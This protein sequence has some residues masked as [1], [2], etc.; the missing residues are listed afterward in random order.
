MPDK[1]VK[2]NLEEIPPI[3]GRLLGKAFSAFVEKFYEKPENHEKFKA[4]KK[5]REAQSV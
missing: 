2:I 1:P 3:E 5:Q 4:W